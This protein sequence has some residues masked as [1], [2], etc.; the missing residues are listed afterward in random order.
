MTSLWTR[1]SAWLIALSAIAVIL[2]ITAAIRH[3]VNADPGRRD[4]LREVCAA[5]VQYS[6]LFGFA[7]VAAAISAHGLIGF[8]RSDMRLRGAW[9]FLLWA[10]LDGAAGL[11]AV[12]LMRRAARGESAL[13]PRLAVWGLVAA[14]SAFNWAHAPDRPGAREAF[15]LMPV[16]AAVLFEFS[17]HE[18]RHT[19]GRADR[20]LGGARWLRPGE[21]VRVQ[22][23]LAGDESLTVVTATQLVRVRGAA[24]AL[25]RLRQ[26]N[27]PAGGP[28]E[29]GSRR[30]ARF[31]RAERRAQVALARVRFADPEVAGLVLREARVLAVTSA[32]ASLS[33][34]EPGAGLDDGGLADAAG[35]GR[36]ADEG[37]AP[38]AQSFLA[39]QV[40]GVIG[41][42]HRNGFGSQ[43]IGQS[44]LVLDHLYGVCPAAGEGC[45]QPGRAGA[46][47]QSCARRVSDRL[48]VEA[49]R[50]IVAEAGRQGV[51]LTQNGL[52]HQLRAR[53]LSIAN[54][55]LRWLTAVSGLDAVSKEARP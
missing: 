38:S 34:P 53:G 19:A 1:P 47:E 13:A 49:A 33:Y 36:P 51:A 30:A 24:W 10:A 23:E 14:S 16:I 9:P 42:G 6:L 27:G 55:R 28:T 31:R 22:L 11:C 37:A 43:H 29:T 32:I 18:T 17:L 2:I 44:S 46:T 26:V 5:L 54:E 25:H 40:N 7:A 50:E 3:L 48:L 20:R 35:L 4:R 21:R 41:N 52:A 12:L 15:A 8:A 45:T 39:D